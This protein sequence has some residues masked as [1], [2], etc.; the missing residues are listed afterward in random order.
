VL[1]CFPVR[2][3]RLY[4]GAQ[5]EVPTQPRIRRL[6]L[7]LLEQSLEGASFRALERHG[8]TA[9]E[10]A[11]EDYCQVVELGGRA[12]TGTS[13]RTQSPDRP[14]V[15]VGF[16]TV[17]VELDHGVGP[18]TCTRPIDMVAIIA[19]PYGLRREGR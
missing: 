17:E 1:A 19:F 15:E 4:D 16:L 8:M 12:R 9:R 14:L 5:L 3:P 13:Q 2:G 10:R 6:G 18:G 11:V 7:Q